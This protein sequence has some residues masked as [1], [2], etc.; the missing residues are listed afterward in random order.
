MVADKKHDKL[1]KPFIFQPISVKTLGPVNWSE[2]GRR[3][4]SISGDLRAI[5]L[6]YQRLTIHHCS[7][8]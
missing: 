5:D 4:A 3:I 2:L 1:G 8:F 6:F 7:T